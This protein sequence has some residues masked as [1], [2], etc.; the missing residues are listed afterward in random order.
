M[1]IQNL[2]MNRT[3]KLFN[4]AAVVT[5]QLWNGKAF[6]FWSLFVITTLAGNVLYVTDHLAQLR[7]QAKDAINYYLSTSL[8]CFLEVKISIPVNSC[9]TFANIFQ[10]CFISSQVIYLWSRLRKTLRWRHNGRDSVSNHQP[11][12]CLFNRLFRRRSKK[13]SKLRVTDL[14][15]F[16]GEFPHKW[17]V[18]RKMFPFDDVIMNHEGHGI[19]QPQK[20][21]HMKLCWYMLSPCGLPYVL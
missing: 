3:K 5:I 4:T 19:T 20:R 7:F 16:T 14:C 21:Q 2:N 15:E 10:M 17:P 12:D 1:L 13:T 18:A 6:S 11:H 9:E 8:F